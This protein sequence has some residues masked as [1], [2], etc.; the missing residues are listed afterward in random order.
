MAKVEYPIVIAVCHR[1]WPVLLGV[2]IRR[3]GDCGTQPVVKDA[4]PVG[5]VLIDQ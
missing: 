2:Q 4:T 5:H 3:C 1:E